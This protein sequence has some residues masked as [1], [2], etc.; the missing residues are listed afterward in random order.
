M[1]VVVVEVVEAIVM[2]E[3]GSKSHCECKKKTDTNGTVIHLRPLSPPPFP[4]L[5]PPSLFDPNPS[6]THIP[7]A[8]KH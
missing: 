1:E 4:P 8:K 2:E 7:K 5:P 6:H 3:V